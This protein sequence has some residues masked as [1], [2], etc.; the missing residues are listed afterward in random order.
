MNAM[1]KIVAMPEVTGEGP[2]LGFYRQ[3]AGYA[4]IA[5]AF[6]G[7][8]FGEL[9]VSEVSEGGIDEAL[10]IMRRGKR[11]A[12]VIFDVADNSSATREIEMLV[13]HGGRSLPIIAIGEPIDLPRFRLLRA[14]GAVD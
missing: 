3:P 9:V 1:T 6:T 12:M 13:Q 11:P 8:N 2:I 14:A 5:D 4:L 10:K 7:H